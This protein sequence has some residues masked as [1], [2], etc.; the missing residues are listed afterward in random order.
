LNN[1]KY[2]DSINCEV[3]QNQI[4]L[5]DHFY[6]VIGDDYDPAQISFRY[7]L[8]KMIT[9]ADVF[10]DSKMA[11]AEKVRPTKKELKN[12]LERL[13]DLFEWNRSHV[14]GSGGCTKIRDQQYR[15]AEF[16]EIYTLVIAK[17]KET[18]KDWNY[19]AEEYLLDTN[20]GSY[21]KYVIIKSDTKGMLF[22]F[23][24]CVH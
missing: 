7:D 10:I 19:R 23:A 22:E 16:K 1:I 4:E 11:Y 15:T 12:P 13:V 8:D 18:L 20:D 6:R 3:L 17:I 5:L 24:N 21:R 9:V 2:K 14:I